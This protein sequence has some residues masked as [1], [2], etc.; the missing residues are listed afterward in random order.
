MHGKIYGS[1]TNL[2]YVRFNGATARQSSST[3][4]IV[5]QLISSLSIH[6]ES[7]NVVA[8]CI[9]AN[10]TWPGESASFDIT[11][12]RPKIDIPKVISYLAEQ[13]ICQFDSNSKEEKI[14]L[15]DLI[16]RSDEAWKSFALA[17]QL[18]ECAAKHDEFDRW[19][20]IIQHLLL[21]TA[22]LVGAN[23]EGIT[24]RDFTARG[25]DFSGMNLRNAKFIKCAFPAGDFSDARLAKAR[26]TDT[27]LRDAIFIN[28]TCTETK[29]EFSHV[30][31]LAGVNY[32]NADLDRAEI[33]ISSTAPLTLDAFNASFGYRNCEG[34][35]ILR[36]INSI[37]DEHAAAKVTLMEKILGRVT[38]GIRNNS[39]IKHHFYASDISL[40]FGDVLLQNPLYRSPKINTF[41][42]NVL[43]PALSKYWNNHAATGRLKYE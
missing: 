38:H 17:D 34:Y 7:K 29:F 4:D 28:A 43:S 14:K 15:I 1:T 2:Q 8:W 27:D 25:F 41:V 42:Q 40:A 13:G 16:E 39:E 31:Q 10:A 26:F 18:Q 19:P 32:T 12:P 21:R 22:D 37:K 33:D 5:K 9:F 36:T 20:V 30:T 23:L 24:I 11:N 3:A 35:G 6:P